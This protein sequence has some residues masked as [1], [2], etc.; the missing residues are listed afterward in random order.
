MN[1][2]QC[3]NE[4]KDCICDY[5]PW[6]P[7]AVIQTEGIPSAGEISPPSRRKGYWTGTY[8]V[9]CSTGSSAD[10]PKVHASALLPW[11]GPLFKV[12]QLHPKAKV[13]TKAYEGDL[14]WDV[15]SV[16]PCTISHGHLSLIQ[17]GIAIQP[18]EG[19]GYVVKDRSSMSL[20]EV[21]THGGV[22]DNGFRGELTI[23]L[24]CEAPQ[25]YVNEGDKIAQIVFVP[26]ATGGPEVVEELDPSERGTKRHGSSG[27]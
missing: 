17:T 10:M 2:E 4:D 7:G 19:W 18:R 24:T 27:R 25:Y 5:G 20:R 15:Y 13:P 26:I 14:G 22:Y 1:C 11:L 6:R 12:K 21:F 9:P 8:P 16:M 23:G 3:K